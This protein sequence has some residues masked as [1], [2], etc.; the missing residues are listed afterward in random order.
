[1]NKMVNNESAILSRYCSRC[2]MTLRENDE[3]M[4]TER[5]SITGITI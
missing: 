4:S 1:M 2:S 3:L 5:V